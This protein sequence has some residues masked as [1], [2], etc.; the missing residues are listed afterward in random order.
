[1]IDDDWVPAVETF[2]GPPEDRAF[3]EFANEARH[4]RTC[5]VYSPLLQICGYDVCAAV[6]LND[7]RLIDEARTRAGW[8]RHFS[9]FVGAD[10]RSLVTAYRPQEIRK[11]LDFLDRTGYIDE[12]AGPTVVAYEGPSSDTPPYQEELSA[13]T[14]NDENVRDALKLHEY[15]Y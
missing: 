5:I 1:M 14:L 6:V 10:L 15:G 3:A 9:G 4:W 11:A 2:A 8:P 12:Y 13:Y 7:I